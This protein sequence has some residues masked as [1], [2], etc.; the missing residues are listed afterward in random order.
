MTEI[1]CENCKKVFEGRSNRR[2]CSL[3][4]R[5]ALAVKRKFWDRKFYY[6]RLCEVNSEWECHSPEQRAHWKKEGDEARE[7]LLRIYGNRP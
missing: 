3:T 6:V 2:H 1:V 4:C 5:N 7:K